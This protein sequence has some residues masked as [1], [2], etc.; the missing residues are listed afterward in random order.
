M[1][2]NQKDGLRDC[3]KPMELAVVWLERAGDGTAAG[4]HFEGTQVRLERVPNVQIAGTVV[5]RSTERES[6]QR[7]LGRMIGQNFKAILLARRGRV[8]L[9]R[10]HPALALTVLAWRIVGGK[11]VLSVQGSIDEYS[12]SKNRWIAGRAFRKVAKIAPRLSH[13][14]ISGAP[15]LDTHIRD[16]L[17]AVNA[18]FA[19]IPNG[20]FVDK[21]R[22]VAASD[23]P[24]PNMRYAV[25][26]GNLAS[27]Q[28]ISVLMEAVD[29]A[30]WPSELPLV[31]V[32]DGED[33]SLVRNRRNV[34][35]LGRLPSHLASRWLAHAYVSLSLKRTDTDMGGH[36][37]WPFKLIESAALSVPIVATSGPGV[38]EFAE[39]MGNVVLI[40]G[41]DGPAAAEA[42]R[43]LWEIPEERALLSRVE[44]A[45]ISELDWSAGSQKLSLLL[46][47]VVE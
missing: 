47:E 3:D 4:G 13:G 42:V 9:A 16:E 36:G 30:A 5:D 22:A 25:Y 44:D 8:L 28:G 24:M 18:S 14:L 45:S 11:V 33:R 31:I 15:V 23:S 38:N 6:L 20:V 21:L 1:K 41:Q 43:R 10:Y 26:V 46:A 40:P 7:R 27:W 37:Y 12:E 29:N 34:V 17:L 39:R 19:S 35:W 32:G 2:M